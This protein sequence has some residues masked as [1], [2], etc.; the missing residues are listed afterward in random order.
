MLFPEMSALAAGRLHPPRIRSSNASFNRL[1]ND[2]QMAAVDA[3]VEGEARH[4]PYIIFGPPGTG[5]TTTVV[6]AVLQLVKH[7]AKKDLYG[8]LYEEDLRVLV[9]TPTNTASDVLCERLS[10]GGLNSKLDMLRL[11]AYSRNKRDVEETVLRH[12][13]WSD[14]E[15]GFAM[16]KLEEIKRP[17]VIVATLSTAAKLYC[18]ELPRGHFDVIVIDESGQATEPEALAAASMLLGEGG[19]LVLAGDPKQLG[20]VIHHTLAKE[21]GLGT[22]VL[23]RLM[24]R[25]IYQKGGPDGAYDARARK[26]RAQLR[27]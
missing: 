26:A 21:H 1:I 8:N 13:N 20:P 22:S 10:D 17:R 14:E 25:Q 12:C 7:V 6:E 9:C 18:E 11:M 27:A 4:V 16:P 15:G 2:Q 3:I 23:E 19:Q 24:E 5:K